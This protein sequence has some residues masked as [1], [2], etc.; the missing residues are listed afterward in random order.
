MR[1]VVIYARANEGGNG[2]KTTSIEPQLDL[3]RESARRFRF[4]V[5]GEFSEVKRPDAADFP[6]LDQAITFA[7][8]QKADL[9]VLRPD[10]LGT[11]LVH[12]QRRVQACRDYRMLIWFSSGHVL[13]A[14]S[15]TMFDELSDEVLDAR[16]QR[17]ANRKEKARQGRLR[18]MEQNGIKRRSPG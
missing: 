8:Q 11:D 18:Y 14:A 5:I 9:L 16:R 4:T 17:M 15:E 2:T 6:Q 1:S 3:L 7:G 13:D 10:R 12:L